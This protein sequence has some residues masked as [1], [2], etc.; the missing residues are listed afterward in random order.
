M[1]N[2]SSD[3]ASH[4]ESLKEIPKDLENVMTGNENNDKYIKN[5]C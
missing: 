3:F 1:K 2:K 4:S 5:R